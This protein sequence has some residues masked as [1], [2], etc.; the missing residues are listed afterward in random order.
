M[1]D[2]AIKSLAVAGALLIHVAGLWL[3]A[4]WFRRKA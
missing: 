3:R 1:T 4:A 2:P